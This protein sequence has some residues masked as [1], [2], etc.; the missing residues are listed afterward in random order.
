MNNCCS[1]ILTIE[2]DREFNISILSKNAVGY[3]QEGPVASV[4]KMECTNIKSHKCA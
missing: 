4:G 2:F 3:S 1:A